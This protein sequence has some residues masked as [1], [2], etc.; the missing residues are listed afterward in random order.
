MHRL[1]VFLLTLVRVTSGCDLVQFDTICEENPQPSTVEVVSTV[2]FSFHYFCWYS[3]LTPSGA[4]AH[5]GAS[6]TVSEGN[7]VWTDSTAFD[8]GT[9]DNVG[10][11]DHWQ[12]LFDICLF[13]YFKIVGVLLHFLFGCINVCFQI[14][15]WVVNPQ[16]PI[17]FQ[18]YPWEAFEPNDL[19]GVCWTCFIVLLFICYLCSS[20]SCLYCRNVV[21]SNFD[22]LI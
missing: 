13:F 12:S 9:T 19:S 4:W 7:F 16:F 6:D 20:T 15:F 8:F 18:V 22:D 3:V 21:L 1:V 5:I 14:V 10:M 17:I 11:D 2:P